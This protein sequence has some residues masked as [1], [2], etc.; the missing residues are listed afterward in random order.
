MVQAGEAAPSFTITAAVSEREISPAAL[1]GK[2]AVLIFHGQRTASA[3]KEVGKAV[4]AAHPSADDVVVG[5]VIDLRK[6]GGL[7]KK[8]AM[9]TIKQNYEKIA[10]RLADGYKPEDYIVI[11][12]DW[13]A[14]ATQAFGFD[15]TDEQAGLAVIGADGK[16]KGIAQ[17]DDLPAQAV[18]FLAA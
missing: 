11:C 13:D 18:K 9:A 4:R 8:V 5:N 17:G 7:W 6:M 3:A 16:V 15:E 10:G 1:A 12:P 2:Q 14:A